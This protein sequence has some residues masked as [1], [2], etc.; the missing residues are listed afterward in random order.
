MGLDHLA[1]VQLVD[2]VGADDDERVGVVLADQVGL[3]PQQVRGAADPAAAVGALERRQHHQARRSCGRG[4]TAGRWPGG[5]TATSGGTAPTPRRRR[6]RSAGSCSAGSRS[7]GRRPAK[8]TAGLARWSVSSSSRPPAPPARTRTRMRGR[9]M[10]RPL[11]GRRA[12][13]PRHASPGNQRGRTATSCCR[14]RVASPAADRRLLVGGRPA[15]PHAGRVGRPLAAVPRLPGGVRLQLRRADDDLRHLLLRAARLAA[16]GRRAVRPRRTAAGAGRRLPARGRRDGAVP[17]RRR[18]RLAAGRPRRPGAGDRRADQHARGL[19]ARP[20]APRA[21]ARAPSSTA[22]RPASAS[23][24]GR[25]APACWCSRS[26][27]R[28]TGCSACSPSS[29]CWPPS[30]RCCCRR[31]RPGCPAR[32]ASLRPRVHVPA[33]APAGLRRRAAAAGR[34][35]GD[36]R[37]LRLARPVAGRRRLRHR[38]PPR[39]RAADPRAQRH[40]HRRLARPAHRPR[41]S[42]RCWSARWSSPSVSSARSSP[43]SPRRRRCC[44]PRRSSPGSA[45]GPRS[46]APS[47]RSPPGSPRGHRAG[48]LAGIFVVGY[49]AFSIPA[50]AAGI[51]AGQLGL[52]RTTEVYGVAVVVLA[53]LAVAALLRARRSRRVARAAERRRRTS[54][55]TGSPPLSC[56]GRGSPSARGPGARRSPPASRWWRRRPRASRRGP[57][58]RGC[59]S[60]RRSSRCRPAPGS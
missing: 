34:L 47:P 33:G 17:V 54:G 18:R 43:C 25:S 55:T 58:S 36:R 13:T 28:P 26:R 10:R 35:L 27:R 59:P 2:R 14:A 7:A 19:A 12:A 29:S 53:L 42:G 20:A 24:S 60:P 11:P 49:L 21:A 46:S 15:G 40:R 48:L 4:P 45:S 8:G 16:R 50:I 32:V 6:C 52:T 56:P 37:A 23:R 1:V 30:A 9:A 38:Q 44:S 41:P 3:P 5:P 51:A 39:R 57:G 22:P 31:A